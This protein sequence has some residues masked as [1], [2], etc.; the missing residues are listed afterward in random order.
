MEPFNFNDT[1]LG[2]LT[3]H[4][5]Y[6]EWQ[7]TVQITPTESIEVIISTGNDSSEPA[8]A[9]PE[10]RE[11]WQTVLDALPKVRDAA[12]A[13]CISR[14]CKVEP[15]H[16][17]SDAEVADHLSMEGVTL[18]SGFLGAPTIMVHFSDGDLFGGHSVDVEMNGQGD[19]EGVFLN[20]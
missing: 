3:W 19:I 16:S 18:Q 10:A 1:T 8:D 11:Q 5:E 4:S 7:G 17:L 9:L 13:F 6:R 12:T 15:D 2:T 20:G 14:Y